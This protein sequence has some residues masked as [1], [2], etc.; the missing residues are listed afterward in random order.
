MKWATCGA[1][2]SCTLEGVH[3]AICEQHYD[4]RRIRILALQQRPRL[5]DRQRNV[6]ASVHAGLHPAHMRSHY[7]GRCLPQYYGTS[8][9][10]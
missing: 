8:S 10:A 4:A 1:G 5:F 7:V 6:C 3:T 2:E 9:G